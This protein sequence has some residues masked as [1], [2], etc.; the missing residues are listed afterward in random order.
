MHSYGG[1]VGTNALYGL[2]VKARSALGIEGGISHLVYVTASAGLEGS[3]LETIGVAEDDQ[4]VVPLVFDIAEDGSCLS[5]DFRALVGPGCSDAETDAYISTLVRWNSRGL[6]QPL[7]HCAWRD[8]PVVYI[9]TAADMMLPLE[10]Q[11]TFVE[12][13]EK[14]GVKVQ[15]FELATGHCPNFT[16]TEEVVRV[17]NAVTP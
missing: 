3:S 17:I 5:R 12:N 1:Q 16:A 15:T 14:T 11:K 13:M 2:G 10:H 4:D 9:Y 6:W 7:Q 8:I